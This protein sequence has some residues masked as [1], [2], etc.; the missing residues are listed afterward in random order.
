MAIVRPL[1][2]V[3]P[4]A[5]SVDAADSKS[6]SGNG[7]GVQVPLGAP[8]AEMA[9]DFKAK[10]D[11]NCLTEMQGLQSETI[12]VHFLAF[13]TSAIPAVAIRV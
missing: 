5:E 7:V 3:A 8:A 2:R 10:N 11:T 6:V 4:M 9:I 13:V 12:E 1:R